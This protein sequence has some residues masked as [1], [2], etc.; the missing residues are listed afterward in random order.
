MDDKQNLKRYF[1]NVCNEECKVRNMK[2][3]T[4]TFQKT[5]ITS[6]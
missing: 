4:K 6:Y 3:N 5:R 1:Q 2:Y